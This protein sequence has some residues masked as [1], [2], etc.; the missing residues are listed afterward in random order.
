Y[1]DTTVH[2]KNRRAMH[3]RNPERGAVK[4]HG[5]SPRNNVKPDIGSNSIQAHSYFCI[6]AAVKEVEAP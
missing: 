1:K 2:E 4:S 6:A 3:R 5:I